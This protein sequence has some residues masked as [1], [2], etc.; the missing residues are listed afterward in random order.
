MP[1]PPGV[2]L[3]CVMQSSKEREQKATEMGKD[4]FGVRDAP[5]NID[6][7]VSKLWETVETEEPG[8]R[9]PWGRKESDMAE[10]LNKNKKTMLDPSSLVR[11]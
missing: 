9:S 2:Q 8:C 4:I 7:N 11:R 6:M 3:G 5:D 1:G 10:Q